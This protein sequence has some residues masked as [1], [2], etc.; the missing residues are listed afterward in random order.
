[1]KRD[2][3]K[4]KFRAWDTY[5]NKIIDWDSVKDCMRGLEWDTLVCDYLLMQFTGLL[6]KNGKEIYEGDILKIPVS[7]NKDLHGEYSLYEVV[8]NNGGFIL[9]YFISQKGQKVPRGMMSAFVTAFTKRD[10]GILLTSNEPIKIEWKVI[11]NIYESK[12]LLTWLY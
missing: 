12:D 5:N 7:L 3:R 10:T 4:I 6:D 9:S 2:K 8:F 11:G 1:M